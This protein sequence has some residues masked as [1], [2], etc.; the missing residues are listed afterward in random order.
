MS[1]TGNGCSNLG[2]TGEQ[3]RMAFVDEVH[4]LKSHLGRCTTEQVNVGDANET[5]ILLAG[6]LAITAQSSL[7]LLSPTHGAHILHALSTENSAHITALALDQ[8]LSSSHTRHLRM[9]S[10]LST[11]EFSIFTIDHHTP[12]LSTRTLTYI[13]LSRNDRTKPIVQAVYHHPIILTLSQSFK[14]SIYDLSHESGIRHV[15]TLSS[16]SSYSPT[17]MVVSPL[18]G[19]PNALKVVLVYTVPVYPND[20]SAGVTELII[21]STSSGASVSSS[22]TIRAFDVPHGWIDDLKLKAL[23]E[24]W[25]RRLGRVV[26]TQT[27]GK[28]VV[29]APASPNPSTT[30]TA[31]SNPLQLYRL[32][33]PSPSSSTGKLT[34]VRNLYG[35]ETEVCRIW[36]A[37]G[38]CVSLGVDGS[39]WVWDLEERRPTPSTWVEG[40][41]VCSPS[42][43]GEAA[44]STVVFDES[45]IVSARNGVVEVRRFDV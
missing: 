11:G 23:K 16:F 18:S 33:L 15:Q 13:P 14:L 45:R 25:G 32:S 42:G 1:G 7:T 17:S 28:W 37:D 30:Q 24:Q 36:V 31:F 26:D 44:G 34:F 22:R 9:A 29:L 20:W 35:P 6:N 40:A 39:M 3:V 4:S 27:D 21:S 41:Q 19:T 38:R 10:F 5:H 12:S 43:G 8:S 2:V